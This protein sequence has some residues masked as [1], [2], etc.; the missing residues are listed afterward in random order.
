M[1]WSMREL[2]ILCEILHWTL[3]VNW[4]IFSFS[5]EGEKSP[6]KLHDDC[7]VAMTEINEK[8]EMM[9][10]CNTLLHA[11][12]QLWVY[13]IFFGSIVNFSDYE[14]RTLLTPSLKILKICVKTFKV[15]SQTLHCLYVDEFLFLRSRD[16]FKHVWGILVSTKGSENDN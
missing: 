13:W 4:F 5:F 6:E 7:Y 11:F 8:I 9:K 3:S 1:F 16:I 2:K 15:F 10:A 12:L 14:M